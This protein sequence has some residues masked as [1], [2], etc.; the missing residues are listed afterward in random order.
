MFGEE[1]RLRI[2]VFDW[3]KEFPRIL[4]GADPGFDAVIG[5]P[6]Y[7]RIQA[8]KEWAPLEVEFYK[9]RYASAGKGNYDI[10]VVFV[11]KGLSLLNG[12][13]RL[14]Y[15]LPHKFFNAQYGEPLRG[16][17]SKGKHLGG[18]RP[19]RRPAGLQRGNDIH[20]P[21]VP[22]QGGSGSMQIREGGRPRCLACRPAGKCARSGAGDTGIDCRGHPGKHDWP[23]RVELHRR[24]G[25]PA[26]RETAQ[27]CQ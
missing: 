12:K 1:E 18:S 20:L 22:G 6:P 7:I 11:E 9:K 16:L 4:G 21:D 10:Y 8:L 27:R 24:T 19:F 15:I 2:N 17:I 26:V 14:G 5:N 13:G 23:C 3:E 25:C